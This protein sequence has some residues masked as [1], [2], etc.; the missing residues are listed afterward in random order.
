MPELNMEQLKLYA[1]MRDKQ[2]AELELKYIELKDLLKKTEDYADKQ[3]SD[4]LKLEELLKK[5]K[6]LLT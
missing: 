2:F 3:Q 6:N 4:K 5:I 1:D